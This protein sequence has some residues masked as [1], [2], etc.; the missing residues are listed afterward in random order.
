M[1][2][3]LTAFLFVAAG[4]FMLAGCFYLPTF[5]TVHVDE[6]HP[7]KDVSGLVGSADSHRPLHVGSATRTQVTTLLGPPAQTS[8][9]GGTIYYTWETQQGIWVDLCGIFPP[10]LRHDET[11]RDYELSLTFDQRDILVDFKLQKISEF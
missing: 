5:E 1:M 2:K 10:H 7:G 9:D 8:Q 4:L 3:K 11:T 6:N